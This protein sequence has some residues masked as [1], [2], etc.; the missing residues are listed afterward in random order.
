MAFELLHKFVFS[1]LFNFSVKS[2]LTSPAP[3][4]LG[5]IL[6]SSA[7]IMLTVYISASPTAMFIRYFLIN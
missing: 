5:V 1:L 2:T 4:A 7:S 3:K 6:D